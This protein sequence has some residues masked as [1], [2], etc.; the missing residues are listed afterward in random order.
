MSKLCPQCA[1]YRAQIILLKLQ[2]ERLHLIIRKL[3]ERLKRIYD[4][5]VVVWSESRGVVGKRSGVKRAV[6]AYHRS[7]F[8]VAVKVIDLVRRG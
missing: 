1:A 6:W 7:R 5:V 3:N 2:I 8:E 4:Y